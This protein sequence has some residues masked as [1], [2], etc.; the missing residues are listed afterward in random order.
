MQVDAEELVEV[1][2]ELV[3]VAGELVKGGRAAFKV[4]SLELDGT[5]ALV[6][7]VKFVA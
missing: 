2:G 5:G 1:A 3:E 7:A 4:E 6:D